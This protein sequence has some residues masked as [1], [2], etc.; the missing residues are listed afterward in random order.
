LGAEKLGPVVMPGS[1]AFPFPIGKRNPARD[2]GFP[3]FHRL[4]PGFSGSLEVVW[5]KFNPAAS[6]FSVR[7][8]STQS[9]SNFCGKNRPNTLTLNPENGPPRA[10]LV[11]SEAGPGRSL[12]GE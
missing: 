6:G 8:I 5:G 7:K 12:W 3:I 10:A 4:L 1:S 9:S 2:A 11:A